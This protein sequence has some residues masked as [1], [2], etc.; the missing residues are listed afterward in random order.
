MQ[1]S[2]YLLLVLLFSAFTSAFAQTGSV[3]GRIV[4]GADQTPLG[5]ANVV[6]IHLPDS[7][8]QGTAADASGNFTLSNVTPGPYVLTASFLGYQTLR[9]TVRVGTQPL[10]LGAVTLRAGG[11]TLKNVEVVG[12]AAA[13]VQK[14]DT[15][16][17]SAKAFKTN[18]DADAQD[19]ITKMPGVSVVDGK[20]QAQG[21][22]VRQ[23]LVDGKQFFGDDAS[24]VLK[25]IPAE[26][27]D[28]IEVFDK[29]SEQAQFSGIDD[30]NAAK[31]INI[32]TKPQFRN[33][34]FGRISVGG[35]PERYRASG[36]INSFQ[37][38]RRISVVAQSNNVNE[39]NFGTEDLLGV[40]GNS[41]QG[42]RRGGQGG[43]A[44]RGGGAG[45][46]QRGG[47]GGGGASDFLTNQNNGINT[48]HALGINYAD[49]WGQK[50]EVT[51]S[52]FF[53]RNNNNLGSNTFRQ[54]ILPS[55]A[56]QN[57]IENSTS[58]SHNTNHRLNFRLDY[59]IDSMN[60]LL[61]R[62]RF[63][64]QQNDGT[65]N[66]L[67]Q[68][69]NGETPVSNLTSNYGSKYN[70]INFNN[71]LLFRHRFGKP[72]RTLSIGAT[73]GYNDK[74][75]TSTLLTTNST[76]AGANLDQ[77]SR[78]TQSGWNLASSINYSE[79]L[80]KQD[81]LQA[82]YDLRYAPSNSDKRTY[83]LNEGDQSY[84]IPDTALSN[85][86]TNAYLTQALGT[87]Y[88]RQTKQFQ[89]MVGVSVQRATLTRDQE[90]PLVTSGRYTFLNALPTAMLQYKFTQQKNLRLN[91]RTNTS[92]PSISQLQEVVNNANPLQL[93]TGN[94]ALKQEYQHNLFLRYSAAKPEKSTNFFALIGGSYTQNPISNSTLISTRDS[95]LNESVTLPAGAQL[96]RPVNLDRQFTLRSFLNYG[97][98]LAA[99][100]SN[101]NLN[102]S[103]TY[104]RTPGLIN[105]ALNYA[106]TPALGAG[107]V[108]S[109]NI[110]E[111]LDFTLSS[112]SNLS[113]VR[114]TLQQQLNTNYFVQNSRARLNW[115]VANG[116]NITTDLTHQANSGL[117]AGFNQ[118]Y[119]L[120]NASVGKKLFAKQQ[121]ELK[122]YAF[123]LLGQNRSIQRNTTET[124][125]EDVRTDILQRYF[126]LMFTYNLRNTGSGPA[127]ARP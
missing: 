47:Q 103:A 79:P 45:G 31:T 35:G 62:P 10:V 127:P 48:T 9:R 119:V 59:K 98:P 61:V 4:D 94:P 67:G 15:A 43:G 26:V 65:N 28:K 33:G 49:K 8:K 51:G 44:P 101:L 55:A 125:I 5:G 40:V 110:S 100:K 71:E 7:V 105:G 14:G 36:N 37:G 17:Y 96:T 74:N 93:T 25:N 16:Q 126:M 22:D 75:G 34:Q 112:N 118:Q 114:N 117:T 86:F 90:F 113:F 53:N 69:L 39:Q 76:V 24:A 81:F 19:L 106:Q 30:G 57:Y 11:V 124:Y 54:Y 89:A 120:W 108:L 107:V 29:K 83:N 111:K 121:G 60:S 115:I 77:F 87:S 32:V 91:Y 70:G 109:S 66:L 12:R 84:S 50:L 78:L 38:D 3:S 2:A 85:V 116:F 68:T 122:L 92:P 27:I 104:S 21:E 41:Q 102:A 46:G 95:V 23:V 64:Y 72:G 80:S 13:A 42:G 63:S 20:V 88:R 6:L 82:S 1:K 97:V 73:T 52:Y 56:D 18:P 58:N 123:D 99:L